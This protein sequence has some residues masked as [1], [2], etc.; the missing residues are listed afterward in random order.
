MALM[1]PETGVYCI[2]L[3]SDNRSSKHVVITP[4]H[5]E[6]VEILMAENRSLKIHTG[7][8]HCNNR[9]RACCEQAVFE[10]TTLVRT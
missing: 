7:H 5:I 1:A 4:A 6:V 10:S 2:G 3:T 9:A 8:G